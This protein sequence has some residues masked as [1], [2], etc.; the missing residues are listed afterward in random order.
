MPTGSGLRAECAT[1]IGVLHSRRVF[2]SCIFARHNQ[3]IADVRAKTRQTDMSPEAPNNKQTFPQWQDVPANG[4]LR[5]SSEKVPGKARSRSLRK[6]PQQRQNYRYGSNLRALEFSMNLLNFSTP[7]FCKCAL[8]A[9]RRHYM[10]IFAAKTAA[11]N[12]ISSLMQVSTASASNLKKAEALV[13]RLFL[14]SPF[15]VPQISSASLIFFCSFFVSRFT[16]P[17][18]ASLA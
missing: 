5:E 11:C 7:S 3:Q 6:S 9:A 18:S 16:Q 10:E 13:S 2:A 15:L 12:E 8:I 14:V 4:I 17:N 1:K